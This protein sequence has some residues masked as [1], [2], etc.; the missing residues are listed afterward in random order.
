MNSKPLPRA[1]DLWTLRVKCIHDGLVVGMIGPVCLA[2][3]R[4]KPTLE[5]FEQQQ[6]ELDAAVA[7]NP[8]KVAFLCV[9]ESTAD[10]PDQEV[11]DASAAMIS[12]HGK[13]L[14][15]TACVIE[16]SGFRAAITRTVLSGMALVARNAAPSRFFEH[17][18]VASAWLGDILGQGSR[19]TGLAKQVEL[20]RERLDYASAARR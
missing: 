16:G 11:R 12:S 6:L 20:A 1:G 19:E 5:L 4:T 15:A 3:W 10:A 17:V 8:G 13:K 7:S 2:I 18:S 9:V 14:A